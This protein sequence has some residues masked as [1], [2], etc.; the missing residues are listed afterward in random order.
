[1]RVSGKGKERAGKQ[2]SHHVEDGAKDRAL[3]EHSREAAVEFV[4]DEGHE[5]QPHEGDGV[6]TRHSE[7]N[8]GEE[9]PSISCR[10]RSF[11]YKVQCRVKILEDISLDEISPLHIN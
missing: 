7:A 9:D 1:M 3:V 10:R 4:T 2:A 8:Y 5:V 6:L 11:L